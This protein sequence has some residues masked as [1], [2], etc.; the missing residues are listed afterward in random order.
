M[1]IMEKLRLIVI[2]KLILELTKVKNTTKVKTKS[3]RGIKS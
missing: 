2:Q 3:V 1:F